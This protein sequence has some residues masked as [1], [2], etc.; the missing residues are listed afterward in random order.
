M[1]RT[2]FAG[3]L[4]LLGA[5]TAS[6]QITTYIAP[7]KPAAESRQLLA[8]ADSARQDSVALTTMANMKAWVDS[9]AGVP[10][11]ATVGMVDSSA[12]INDPGR[13]ITTF[14]DGAVAPAT[15]SLLPTLGLLGLLLFGAGVVLLTR[16][17]RG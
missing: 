9:A 1:V 2:L 3:V 8:S 4:L 16:R 13:P 15:A 6:A 5:G 7:P 11:P 10:V 14:Q 12:I 17:V